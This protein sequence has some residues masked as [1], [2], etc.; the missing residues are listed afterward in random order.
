[1]AEYI[2]REEV[3]NLLYMF[4]DESCCS[5]VSDVEN[6]PAADVAQVRHA[7]WLPWEWF[8]VGAA[9]GLTQ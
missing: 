4:A 9:S 1:M 8:A 3:I 7:R 2:D 5:I 6:L